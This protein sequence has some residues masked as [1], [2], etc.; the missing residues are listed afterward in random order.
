MNDLTAGSIALLTA[1]WNDRGNWDG[2]PLYGGNVGGSPAEN[3]HL[4]DL[5][6]KGY[7]TTEQDYDDPSLSWVIFTD[8]TRATFA[9]KVTPLPELDAFFL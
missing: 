1:L 6:K 2:M 4:T 8:K 9:P 5:K 3:G 7:V